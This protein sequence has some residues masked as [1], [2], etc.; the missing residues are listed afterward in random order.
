VLM[1]GIQ[2]CSMKDPILLDRRYRYRYKLM[3][4]ASTSFAIQNIEASLLC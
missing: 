3:N 1:L 2:K 4:D